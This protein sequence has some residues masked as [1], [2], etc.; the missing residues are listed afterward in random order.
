[1]LRK[2]GGLAAVPIMVGTLAFVQSGESDARDG[3][4]AAHP[5]PA[6]AATDVRLTRVRLSTGVELEVAESGPANGRPVLFLHGYTDSWFSYSPILGRLSP[7]IRAIVPTQRGHGESDKPTCCY[8]IDDFASDAIALLDELGVEHASVV[9]H[10]MGSFV[11]QRIAI[12]HPDRVDRLVLIGAGPTGNVAAVREFAA[13]VRTLPDT[14]PL[15]FRREFQGSTAFEPLPEAF[16]RAV[17]E[18]SGKLPGPLWREAMDG[19]LAFDATG[20]LGRIRGSTL[21]VWGE[22]DL[23]M[24]RADQDALLRGI[25]RARLVA[26]PDMAHCPNW[27]QPER[28]A[29]DLNA[30][31]NEGSPATG[32]PELRGTAQHQSHARVPGRG[33]MPILEGLGDWQHPAVRSRE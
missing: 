4:G 2:F 8:R 21:I 14:V 3:M 20:E 18:E 5:L 27:E 33:P 22:H 26:Y 9:G 28:F 30:F 1:M 23:L 29:A 17:V 31:L 10:S 19:I 24:L 12:D 16:L 32:S 25:P 11:A 7:D 15:D 13:A 6:S